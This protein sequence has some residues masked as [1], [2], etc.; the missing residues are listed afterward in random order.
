MLKNLSIL[1][2]KLFFLIDKILVKIFKKSFLIPLKEFI[3]TSSYKKIKVLDKQINFFIPNKLIE[4]RVDTFFVN[5]P[6]TLDWID[7]FKKNKE[8]IFWDIGANIGLYSIYNAL[9]NNNSTTISFEPSTSNLRTLSRNIYINNLQK[10]I[11]IFTLPLNQK[12]NVFL[13]M[14]EESFKEGGALNSFGSEFNFEGKN[15][16]SNMNYEL[17][18]TSINFLLDN[19]LLEI[20]DY[21][22]IDVDGIEHLILEGGNQFLHNKKV[23][24][25]LIEINEDFDEQYKKTLNIMNACN[26][27]LID[28]KINQQATI[29]T[30]FSKIYNYIF[31]KK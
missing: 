9:K 6:E 21:I 31:F 14:K 11:K 19:K 2:F 28:K 1:L 4:W 30:K 26:F 25:L 24:S 20:P 12:D 29:N 22:K 23:K 5:E 17:F 3:E 7:N 27:E 15:F 16:T 18:G 10:K 8:I 13:K